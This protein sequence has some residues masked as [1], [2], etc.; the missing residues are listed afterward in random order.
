LH[1]TIRRVVPQHKIVVVA[2]VEFCC[3]AGSHWLKK[4]I[5]IQAPPSAEYA[6]SRKGTTDK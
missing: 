1:R 6:T 2:D 3:R 4:E 5:I